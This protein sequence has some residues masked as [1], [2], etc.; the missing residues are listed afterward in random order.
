MTQ[1]LRTA[2]LLSPLSFH[3]LCSGI[4][5]DA[6]FSTNTTTNKQKGM[7]GHDIFVEY[8]YSKPSE[9]QDAE[10]SEMETDTES[11]GEEKK[12]KTKRRKSQKTNP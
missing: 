5:S 4:R 12:D 10:A 1:Y 2:T 8:D 9:D 7:K 6:C 3:T 11:A